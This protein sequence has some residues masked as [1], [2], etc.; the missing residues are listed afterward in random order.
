MV[1]KGFHTY[2]YDVILNCREFV[3]MLKITNLFECRIDIFP[4][5]HLLTSEKKEYSF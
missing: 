2:L 5:E 1:T 3:Q 4:S